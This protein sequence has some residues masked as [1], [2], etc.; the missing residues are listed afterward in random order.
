MRMPPFPRTLYTLH[1]F[2]LH[3]G[4]LEV[5]EIS[6]FD[7]ALTAGI[8]IAR[9]YNQKRIHKL[10]CYYCAEKKKKLSQT[11]QLR[12]FDIL[13]IIFNNVII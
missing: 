12:D 7:L 3:L 11:S 1:T 6:V 9:Y 4:M 8:I 10:L 5:A 2:A 13:F